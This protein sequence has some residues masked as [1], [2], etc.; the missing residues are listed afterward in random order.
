ML[1][2]VTITGADDSTNIAD[3]FA[4][5]DEFPFVEFGIL[6]G[7]KRTARY[8]SSEWINKLC[9]AASVREVPA[10]FSLHVCG[11]HLRALLEGLV[12]TIHDRI[13]RLAYFDRMQLNFHG[14]EQRPNVAG[15]LMKAFDRL[16]QLQGWQ[17]DVIVQLDG[18]NN[19]LA[20]ALLGNIRNPVS[21]LFDRSHGEGISPEVWPA[22][23]AYH[24]C[25][26]AGGLGPDNLER[27]LPRI[28]E[29]SGTQPY[30]I[31][32]ETKM[33]G[34]DQ[35]L[36]IDKCRQALEICEAFMVAQGISR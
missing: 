32:M 25:G 20:P 1:S 22:A 27:E 30:W 35:H 8:P 14:A 9:D 36:S 31:D 15:N 34:A 21:G 11:V 23:Y 3:L 29:A 10:A 5:S 19:H 16:Y 13:R 24:R 18:V 2:R 17:G 26:Y 28:W 7:S 12:N 33:M 6:I 4:L